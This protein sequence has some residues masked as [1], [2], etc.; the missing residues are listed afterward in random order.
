[1]LAEF[2]II[3]LLV[4][5]NGLFAG[6][7]IAVI[8]VRRSRMPEL[9]ETRGPRARSLQ[10]LREEPDRFLATVQIGITVVGTLAAAFGGASIARELEPLLRDFG[11]GAAAEDVAFALVVALISYL[12]LVLGEL[13]PK[14]LALRS[15]EAYALAA[16]APMLWLGWIARPVVWFLTASSNLLLRPLGDRTTFSEGRLSAEELG[17]LVS[18]ATMAGEVDKH[19]AEIA[20]RAL[21]FQELVVSEV[22]VPR[23]KVVA[24]PRDIGPEEL[25]Q[26]LLERGHS[27]MP[28]YEDR[29]TTSWATSSR[30]ICLVRARVRAD[31]P[32]GLSPATMVRAGVVAGNPAPAA[33]AGASGSTSN[34]RGRSWIVVRFGHH[35]GPPGGAGGRDLQ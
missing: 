34:L 16:A 24:I 22:M 19:S 13:V 15:A 31:Q 18:E 14:S 11:L 28:V 27:R 9:L 30:A 7:E 8:S 35:G 6:A 2:G 10:R 21:T 3:L 32:R 17:Q 23:S 26:L 12:S 4:V 33:D 25:R 29:W 1:M 5:A 20:T